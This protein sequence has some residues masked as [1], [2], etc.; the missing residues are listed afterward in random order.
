M[1]DDDNSHLDIPEF[2]RRQKDGTAPVIPKPPQATRPAPLKMSPTS[3]AGPVEVVETI[4][5]PPLSDVAVIVAKRRKVKTDRRIA[6]LT[7]S[8][9]M[10]NIPPAFRRWDQRRSKWYDS[11]I[12][13]RQKLLAAAARLGIKLENTEMDKYTVQAY[14]QD[15]V[16]TRGTAT[17]P[18]TAADFEIQ[19]KL[20]AV[21]KRAGLAKVDKIEVIN[22]DGTVSE[23][24]TVDFENKLLHK[25]GAE[26]TIPTTPPK[27]DSVTAAKQETTD[28]AATAKKATKAKKA[29]AKKAVAKKAAKGKKAAA[30]NARKRVAAN[31]ASKPGVIATIIETMKRDKG[32]SQEEILA[33]LV[34]KFPDREEKGMRK[35]IQIQAPKHAKKK[36]HDDK[37]GLVYHG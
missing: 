9:D 26:L 17:L 13:D 22:P 8:Q 15:Q 34:K 14:H 21:A 19:A 23:T 37:R 2:L 3:Q 11:R 7:S 24:W 12:V 25:S 4:Q 10:K 5:P 29:P 30:S 33:V 16:I 31:G 6:K 20:Q 32:G 18:A 28:M 35:T 36:V 1:P 27:D